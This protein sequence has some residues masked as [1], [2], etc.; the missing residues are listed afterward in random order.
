MTRYLS[1][2][3]KITRGGA[4]MM[5]TGD[6]VMAQECSVIPIRNVGIG[7]DY[8]IPG[9]DTATTHWVG[10]SQFAVSQ[11]CQLDGRDGQL[12][13]CVSVSQGAYVKLGWGR[14]CEIVG[15]NFSNTFRCGSE[16]RSCHRNTSDARNSQTHALIIATGYVTFLSIYISIAH[17]LPITL[18]IISRDCGF[19]RGEHI[20]VCRTILNQSS[21]Y[22]N[23]NQRYAY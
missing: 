10:D 8:E 5:T 19:G 2:D 13:V 21:F 11:Q 23:V 6:C 1:P 9:T 3:D 16:T 17:L 15:L 12:T 18:H 14:V 4:Y 22:S 7:F 20:L